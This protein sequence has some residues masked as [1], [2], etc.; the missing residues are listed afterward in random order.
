MLYRLRLLRFGAVVSEPRLMG[1]ALLVLRLQKTGMQF[2]AD[3]RG[4]TQRPNSTVYLIA[5]VTA[6]IPRVLKSAN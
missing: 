1:E 5:S 2:A 6:F 3:F 4:T